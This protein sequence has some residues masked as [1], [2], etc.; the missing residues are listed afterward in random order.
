MNRL[1]DLFDLAFS[2]DLLDDEGIPDASKV[3][4]A[5]EDLLVK[6]PHLASRRARSAT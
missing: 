3:A 1:S 6:K 5:I 4:N 2:H